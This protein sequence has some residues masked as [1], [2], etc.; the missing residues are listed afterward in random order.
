[1]TCV[2]SGLVSLSLGRL[3]SCSG[4]SEPPV[5]SLRLRVEES[6][7]EDD[8]LLEWHL[9]VRRAAEPAAGEG[10]GVNTTEQ[11]VKWWLCRAV[12]SGR[13]WRGCKR[14][15]RAPGKLQC[16]RGGCLSSLFSQTGEMK[17][18]IP[19]PGVNTAWAEAQRRR[20]RLGEY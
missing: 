17:G 13:A 3:C 2:P 10:S 18:T 9:D 12:G 7:I 20:G 5:E 16:C 1:M 8:M 15:P 11:R 14:P 19:I 6:D 4:S